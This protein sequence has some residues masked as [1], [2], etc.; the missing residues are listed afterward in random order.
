[1]IKGFQAVVPFILNKVES[2]LVVM[3]VTTKSYW[4]WNLLPHD[5]DKEPNIFTCLL[6]LGASLEKSK[7]RWMMR[8][9]C[10]QTKCQYQVDFERMWNPHFW[11]K[12]WVSLSLVQ[13]AIY[14]KVFN[15]LFRKTTEL[16]CSRSASFRFFGQ[17]DTTAWRREISKYFR[18]WLSDRICFT[19]AK[20]PALHWRELDWK[21][22][23]AL[24]T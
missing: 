7:N 21:W 3:Q 5:L 20:N 23:G 1:M 9:V 6:G 11:F 2:V 16:R 22:R 17:S 19:R 13:P 8:V 14:F 24:Y 12:I 18:T 15:C 10:F 4:C